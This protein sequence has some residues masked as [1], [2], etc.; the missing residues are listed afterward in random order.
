MK[1]YYIFLLCFLAVSLYSQSNSKID[2]LLILYQKDKNN[3]NTIR[4]LSREFE[5]I[6]TEKSIFYAQLALKKSKDRDEIIISN[7]DLGET[8]FMA[9]KIDSA[10]IYLKK[11]VDNDFTNNEFKFYF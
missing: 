4:K 6:N 11:S 7:R 3:I 8:Y 5:N 1:K 9:N 2:S 10:I